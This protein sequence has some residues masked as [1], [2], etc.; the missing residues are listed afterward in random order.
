MESLV[1][2]P[3]GRRRKK[4]LVAENMFRYHVAK[5]KDESL[6]SSTVKEGARK[7][8]SKH[9][10]MAKWKP[11]TRQAG[12]SRFG[13]RHVCD[14]QPALCTIDA[15]QCRQSLHLWGDGHSHCTSS[16]RSEF[17]GFRWLH[18]PQYITNSPSAFPPLHVSARGGL[19]DQQ[20]VPDLRAD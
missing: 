14:A 11:E 2:G 8:N 5:T 12:V 19:V 9:R 3:A 7:E 4:E 13:M 15:M 10:I 18:Y 16:N 6:S 17:R 1:E 20:D